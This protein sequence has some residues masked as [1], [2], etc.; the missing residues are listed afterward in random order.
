MRILLVEDDYL[1]AEFIAL[2]I[3]EAF[4][5]S[6]IMRVH[7]E[8]EFRSHFDDIASNPPDIII[9]GVLLRW[10]NPSAEMEMPPK[11][12]K[13]QG[14]YR[15]GFRCIELLSN[16]HRTHDVPV[17]LHTILDS[18]DIAPLPD[19]VRYVS[20]D[21]DSSELIRHMSE[22]AKRAIEP[23]YNVGADEHIAIA[24]FGNTIKLVSLSRDG[25][26]RF[27]DNSDNLHRILYVISSETL[28]LETAVDEFESLINSIKTKESDLQDFFER[29][30]D[31]ILN[32]EYQRAHPHIALSSTKGESLIPDFVLEPVD[33][34]ALCDLLEL[35]LPSSQAF[36]LQK[37]RLRFSAAVMEACA[38]LRTYSVFF[39]EEK[40]RAS[41]QAKYG[42]LAYRPKMFVIIGRRGKMNP[43]DIRRIA[44][45]IPN[46]HLVTYDQIASRMK[47]KIERMKRRSLRA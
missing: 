25:T 8:F 18:M 24:L 44:D 23:E 42:L 38:Q 14:Y 1:Q 35:K 17:I 32:D 30:P 3:E 34:Y 46:L 10:A 11:E 39:D 26:Y 40:N 29:Y 4:P 28:A 36:V 5:R 13:E 22:L 21:S 7:T 16:D 9:M 33:Q 2:S 20:K 45:D 15:A 12:V 19:R 43:I 31:F 41:V 6:F 27:V 47:T 37:N